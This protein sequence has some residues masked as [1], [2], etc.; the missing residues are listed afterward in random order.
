MLTKS[1]IESCMMVLKSEETK[2]GCKILSYHIT[3]GFC[4]TFSL[5][6]ENKIGHN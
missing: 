5:E 6:S 3:F 4:L 2:K 1:D